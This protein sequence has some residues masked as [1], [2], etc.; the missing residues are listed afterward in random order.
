MLAV[1]MIAGSPALSYASNRLFRGRRPVL[2]LASLG[3]VTGM[4][5]LVCATGG[6]AVPWLYAVFFLLGV[7]T[8]A[9]VV[10]GFTSAKEL[11]PVRM[12]GTSTGLVNL[13]PFAGGAV[14]Q[15]LLGHI[16]ESSGMTGGAFTVTGYRNGFAVLLGCAAAALVA[17]LF[18]KETMRRTK[19]LP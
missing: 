12:A 19:E 15:P 2:I 6:I 11:F 3:A 1:G 10:I 4:I 18:V 5:P 16:I 14:F 17:S 9:I 8:N 7:S 13:F